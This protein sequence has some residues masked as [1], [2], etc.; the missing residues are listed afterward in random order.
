MEKKPNIFRTFIG[1]VKKNLDQTTGKY[2]LVGT[3]NT[4]VASG[5]MFLSYNLLH[6]SYWL[7]SALNY[8]LGSILSFFLNKYFTF[9][10]QTKSGYELIKFICNIAVC[11][12]IAYGIAKPLAAAILTGFGSRFQDNIAMVVGMCLFALL[13][14]FGQRYFVF[15][16]K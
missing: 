8:T 10:S 2:L 3:V 13:N 9:R 15:R 11:Y 16:K 7:S 4:I 6:F 5:I 12:F 14:Y 1:F